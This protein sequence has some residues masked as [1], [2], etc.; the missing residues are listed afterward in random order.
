VTSNDQTWLIEEFQRNR[1]RLE[2]VAYRLLGS[3]GEAEEAV[4]EAYLRLNRSNRN[5]IANASGW[6][7]TV[8][9]RICLDMLRSRKMRAEEEV[10]TSG[11][12]DPKQ[13]TEQ[14]ALLAES[15]GLAVLVV[16]ERLA[17]AERIAFVLHD[18]FALPFEEIAAILQRT[19]ISTRQLASR[20]RRRVQGSNRP[21]RE[22]LYK[23]RELV[24]TF[25]SALRNGDMDSIL[26]VLDPSVA[27]YADRFAVADSRD[28][29]LRGAAS[30]AKEAL[31]HIAAARSATSV[32]IEGTV[33]FIVAP[34]GHLRMALRCEFAG[35]YITRFDVIADP[36]SLRRVSISPI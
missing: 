16:L 13:D 6:L 8:V 2:A 7:T 19:T 18:M 5:D 17:P 35:D 27:R 9:A 25:L 31:T 32:L 26:K 12:I 24:E 14:D 4:Q 20:A 15:V 33:G 11:F 28:L 34:A 30:V 36:E 22:E 29:V 23:Q 21:R 1:P 3:T 10:P